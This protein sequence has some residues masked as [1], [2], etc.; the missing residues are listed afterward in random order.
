MATVLFWVKTGVVKRESKI[1][2]GFLSISP[3]ILV[4]QTKFEYFWNP[5]EISDQMNSSKAPNSKKKIMNVQR[6]FLLKK[7]PQNRVNCEL[8]CHLLSEKHNFRAIW[9]VSAG[10][11]NTANFSHLPGRIGLWRL[12]PFILPYIFL[13]YLI[14]LVFI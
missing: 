13:P 14:W 10:C 6:Y 9:F 1:K 12:F 5:C 4:L 7:V 8:K 3:P 11:L 2:S